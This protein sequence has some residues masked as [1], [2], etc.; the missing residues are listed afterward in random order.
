MFG[1]KFIDF[2]N[3]IDDSDL[4]YLNYG[5][6][7]Q[8]E[9]IVDYLKNNEKTLKDSAQTFKKYYDQIQ[10]AADDEV[11]ENNYFENQEAIEKHTYY[12]PQL[13][14]NSMMIL[15]QNFF[16]DYMKQILKT[17]S[18]KFGV[19]NNLP[20]NIKKL[21]ISELIKIKTYIVK[22]TGLDFYPIK[23]KW[24]QI[25]SLIRYRNFIVHD[26]SNI[27]N[28]KNQYR[29]KQ[30]KKICNRNS[31][32]LLLTDGKLLLVNTK[33]VLLYCELIKSVTHYIIL[34]SDK[35]LEKNKKK[36]KLI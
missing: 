29:R 27:Y 31:N 6:E 13:F 17:L 4:A 30:I 34:K 11:W 32:F 28:I 9:I 5:G 2:S 33:Y 12:F 8:M 18:R 35:I 15:T 26:N 21:P 19:K 10:N 23:R 22:F 16:E 7:T 1:T 36:A 20:S 14:H 25:E 3:V 24:K